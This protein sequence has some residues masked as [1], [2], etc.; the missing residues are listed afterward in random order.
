[1]R[2]HYR[3]RRDLLLALLAE[4]APAFRPRGIAAGLQLMLEIGPGGPTEEGLI[5]RAQQHSLALGGLRP[6]WHSGE[7]PAGVIFGYAAPAQH[8][9]AASLTALRGALSEI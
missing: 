6:Y 8:E 2:Q 7:G 4:H 1:M 3:R 9:Y 5:D